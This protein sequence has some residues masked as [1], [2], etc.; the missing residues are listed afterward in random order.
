[1]KKS[2]R[3]IESPMTNKHRVNIVREARARIKTELKDY[4][5]F[6]C[7]KKE[8][9]LDEYISKVSDEKGYSLSLFYFTDGL[10][11]NKILGE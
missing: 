7:G 5:G 3:K 10:T 9:V 8:A 6:P 2:K 1:M 4:E 11:L